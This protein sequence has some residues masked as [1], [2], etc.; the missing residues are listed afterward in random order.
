VHPLGFVWSR[1]Q[2]YL[3]A[4]CERNADVRVFRADR[5]VTAE[6]DAASFTPPEG[7]SLD[8]VLRDGNVLVGSA[9]ETMRVRYSKKV[10]RFVAEEEG[11]I[12]EPD[13]TVVADYPVYDS[14]WA[15]RRVLR[16]APEAVI[17]SPEGIREMAREALERIAAID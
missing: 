9:T 15:V 7:F 14:Q 2:W 4:W 16:W 6:T 1:G 13:G 10:A 12:P 3:A 17:E 8:S 5:I 11:I